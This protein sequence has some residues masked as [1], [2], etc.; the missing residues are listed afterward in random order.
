MKPNELEFAAILDVLKVPQ[1]RRIVETLVRNS[2]DIEQLI[3]STKL[4][5]RSLELHMQ[6]LVDAKLVST[7]TITGKTKYTFA[8]EYFAT[9]ASWFVK[10][11]ND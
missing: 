5:E 2:S 7:R 10:I 11:L 9:H 3:K 8:S 6:L 4:S 1:C